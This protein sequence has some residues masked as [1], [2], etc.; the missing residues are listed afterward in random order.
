MKQ[1]L[2]LF[3]FVISMQSHGAPPQ[4]TSSIRFANMRL[5]LTKGARKR[6]QEKVDSLT[7]SE[8]HFQILLNRANLFM[9]I[10]ERVLKEENLPLDFKYVAIQ[11]SA[12]ISDAVS[13]TNDVGFWQFQEATA[14]EV[15]LKIDHHVDERMHIIE[16]TRAA[17]R[18]LKR[19]NLAFDNW[20][21]ALLSYNEGRGGAQKWVKKRYLGAKTMKI[22]QQA[23]TYIIHFLAHKFV[24]DSVL[25]KAQHPELTLYEYQAVH[26]K[27]LNEISS[28]LGVDITQVKDYNKWLKRYRVPQDATCAVIIP[29]T[30]QQYVRYGTATKKNGSAKNKL[31]YTKYWDK[32]VDFPVITS[33]KN[34]KKNTNTTII[35]NIL[36]VVAVAGNSSA[37]LAKAGKISLAQFLTYNDLDKDSPIISGQVYYY[38]PKRNKANV[39]FHIAR[40]GETW[41]SVAQKYGIKKKELLLKNRLR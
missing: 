35:N 26:G 5:H 28:E 16:A 24:F 13:V 11:E 15:G 27:S 33:P 4:V 14:K 31:N 12:L 3:C 36:G 37:S 17:A 20:L 9:P 39:H 30:H 25:G 18:Y 10:V 19:N 32:A 38:K 22:E 21:Y 1:Y 2:L 8:K 7:R 6:I 34:K 40:P 29:M 41:W 23:H